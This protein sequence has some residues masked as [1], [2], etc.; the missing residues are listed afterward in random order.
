MF[1]ILVGNLNQFLINVNAN[2]FNGTKVLGNA[3]GD[4]T[5]NTDDEV[6]CGLF[7]DYFTNIASNVKN[8]FIF[9]PTVFEILQS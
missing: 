1:D 4:M 3:D 6:Y 5:Y 9:K 7:S 8:F 2:R